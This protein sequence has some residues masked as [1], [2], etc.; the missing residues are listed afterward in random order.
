M[1]LLPAFLLRSFFNT[2]SRSSA[3]DPHDDLAR[4]ASV[5]CSA[6]TW[7]QNFSYDPFGNLT[8]T[9]PTGGTGDSFQPTYNP[10]TNRIP[11]L[12][13][14]TPSYDNNGNVLNDSLHQYTW[15]S[16]GRPVTIDTVGLTF[17]AL[18]RAVEFG[19]ASPYTQVVYSV[20]GSKLALMNGQSLLKAR[21]PLPSGGA[22]TYTNS[23][24]AFYSHADWLGSARFFSTPSQTMYGDVAY[25]PFGETYAQSG[26]TDISFTGQN[27]DTAGGNYDFLFRQYNIQGRWASPDPAGLAAVS[28]GSPQ[29]WNRYAYVLNNP[30][31]LLDP[32]GLQGRY[33]PLD[34]NGNDPCRQGMSC[35]VDGFATDC[36]SLGPSYGFGGG[37]SA[38][39]WNMIEVWTPKACVSA[40]GDTTCTD[41]YWTVDWEWVPGI[42]I[43]SQLPGGLDGGAGRNSSWTWNFTKSFFTFAGGPGNKPTCAGQTLR[44]IANDMA[45]GLFRSQAAETSLKAASVYQTA[46]ALQYA[47]GRPNSLGGIGLICPSC[48]SVFRSMM[49]NAEFLGEASEAV[50]LIETSYAAGSSIPEVSG[51]ARSGECAAAFPIF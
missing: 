42:P 4:I 23:G 10:V 27:S 11:S 48:S 43:P 39:Y 35:A 3:S 5:D 14:F 38:G 19:T 20:D 36:G 15:D 22:A 45:G 16:E 6:T 40:G 33:C 41:G 21:I 47:A 18:G 7:Q 12:P 8:K 24:L 28:L 46:A 26:S 44:S 17:D 1:R 32:L 31:G 37:G 49:S 13:G 50:P 34:A 9:V 29:S 30:A 2:P 25:A 51:Q